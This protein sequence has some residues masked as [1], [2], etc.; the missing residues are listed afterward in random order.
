MSRDIRRRSKLTGL[1]SSDLIQEYVDNLTALEAVPTNDNLNG[2]LIYVED[3]KAVFAFHVSA[4]DTPDGSTIIE[5]DSGTG[6]WFL[7]S[8]SASAPPTGIADKWVDPTVIQG[9]ENIVVLDT[10][11]CRR[12]NLT[13]DPYGTL[14]VDPGGYVYV[15]DGIHNESRPDFHQSNNV[16]ADTW[17]SVPSNGNLIMHTTPDL[18]LTVDGHLN[19]HGD[20]ICINFF[21]V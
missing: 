20:L 15:T 4:T 3:Q 19:V 8:S 13:I 1:A 11:E 17:R 7:I 2:T 14:T 9:S 21:N 18:P 10:W 16:P 5:P 6:R 12:G